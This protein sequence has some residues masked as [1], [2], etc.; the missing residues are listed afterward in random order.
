[1]PTDAYIHETQRGGD[2]FRDHPAL[3]LLDKSWGLSLSH[4]PFPALHDGGEVHA[5]IEYVLYGRNT[6]PD[7]VERLNRGS[8]EQGISFCWETSRRRRDVLPNH[9]L[10][11]IPVQA[12]ASSFGNIIT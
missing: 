8:P 7:T 9:I 2:V 3:A 10:T 6:R 1:M 4:I 11:P 5:Q 12:N